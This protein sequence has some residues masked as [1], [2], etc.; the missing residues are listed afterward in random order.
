MSLN[1]YKALMRKHEKGMGPKLED[2]AIDRDERSSEK[3]SRP[4]FD[5]TEA[6][7]K[8]KR[9]WRTQDSKVIS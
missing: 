9:L 2:K 5:M 7:Q 8:Q 6:A 1:A 3:N 4:L